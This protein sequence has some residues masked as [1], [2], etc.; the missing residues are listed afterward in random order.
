MDIWHER[1][2]PKL[3]QKS[4]DIDQSQFIEDLQIL[5][6]E[7]YSLKVLTPFEKV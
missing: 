3:K 6:P 5:G 1:R 2:E 4:G 7:P